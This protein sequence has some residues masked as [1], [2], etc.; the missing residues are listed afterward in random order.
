M[1]KFLIAEGFLEKN[2]K[3]LT[4][5]L[6]GYSRP[7]KPHVLRACQRLTDNVKAGDVL[8][9]HF[10]GHG[11]QQVDPTGREDDGYDETL[12][13]CDGRHVALKPKS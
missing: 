2:I 7:T 12:V 1:K 8:F 3:V 13:C 4:D 10:V 11:S 5:D 9:F 6:N